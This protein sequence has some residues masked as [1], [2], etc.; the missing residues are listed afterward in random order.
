LTD[1]DIRVLCVDD[2]PDMNAAMQLTI[3]TQ[4]LMRC[5][6]CLTSADQLIATVRGMTLPPHVVLLDATM[7][8]KRPMVV[9]S[10]LAQQHPESRVIVC[11]GHETPAIVQEAKDAGAWGFVSKRHDPD[12]LMLAVREVAAGRPFW[13]TPANPHSVDVPRAG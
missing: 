3:D 8:G 2:N 13:P 9:L 5:V 10:A 4:P 12:R 7:P 1:T 6:G 11:S